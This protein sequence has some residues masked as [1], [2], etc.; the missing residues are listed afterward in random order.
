MPKGFGIGPVYGRTVQMI[1]GPSV[2]NLG[3]S[4]D[5]GRF[6]VS[7]VLSSYNYSHAPSSLLEAVSSVFFGLI[8]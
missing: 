4:H 5:Q 8:D 3:R 1:G 6:K 7:E 2:G